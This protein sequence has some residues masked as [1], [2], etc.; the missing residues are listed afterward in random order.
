MEE[1]ASVLGHPPLPAR[2][3][4]R[5]AGEATGEHGVVGNSPV[6]VVRQLPDVPLGLQPPVVGVDPRG[7]PIYLGGLDC[8]PSQLLQSG[9]EPA[10]TCEEV[11]EVEHGVKLKRSR[12]HNTASARRA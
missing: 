6:G 12:R 9:V 7:V 3:A 2:L 4:E 10:N 5:L 8:T 1:R 11:Y